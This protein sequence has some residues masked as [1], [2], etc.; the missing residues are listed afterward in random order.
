MHCVTWAN[1]TDSRLLASS[2]HAVGQL[3]I[4]QPAVRHLCETRNG[5][6]KSSEMTSSGGNAA[7]WRDYIELCLIDSGARL[8]SWTTIDAMT[9][10]NETTVNRSDAQLLQ[11]DREEE[12]AD[13]CADTADPGGDSDPGGA[14]LGRE[15]LSWVDVL[16]V[17]RRREDERDADEGDHDQPQHGAAGITHDMRVPTR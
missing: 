11:T 1:W 8:G 10:D 3:G 12:G 9:T 17:G 13:R 7:T 5:A 14:H 2:A 16:Q 4:G 15:H 6:A